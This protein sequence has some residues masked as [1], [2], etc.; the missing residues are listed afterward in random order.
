MVW[1]SC[2]LL[3]DPKHLHLAFPSLPPSLSL[4]PV[5][6]LPPLPFS[7]INT[8]RDTQFVQL[9][10]LLASPFT[11]CTVACNFA[12]KR[13]TELEFYNVFS[14]LRL[15]ICTSSTVSG[16]SW[17]VMRFLVLC[18]LSLVLHLAKQKCSAVTCHATHSHEHLLLR[19]ELQH[20]V[21]GQYVILQVQHRPRPD[22]V[23]VQISD[24]R[25]HGT[26]RGQ[27]L[28]VSNNL[29]AQARRR[30]QLCKHR[31]ETGSG[32]N[33]H[34]NST[35]NIQNTTK[36]HTHYQ[37]LGKDRINDIRKRDRT[38]HTTV[39]WGKLYE[40]CDARRER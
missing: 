6:F 15:L 2:A 27:F 36:E 4:L 20:D 10:S 21:L 30:T 5:S 14:H 34:L 22:L 28:L 17:C 33:R 18:T 19:K 32:R 38:R 23:H 1:L 9:E 16:I 12:F 26:E 35:S 24:R 37:T 29:Q 31:T 3:T 39:Q 25:K 11:C 13:L 40:W 8:A 7:R